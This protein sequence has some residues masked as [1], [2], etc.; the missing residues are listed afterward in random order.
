[1]KTQQRWEGEQ[2][3][4]SHHNPTLFLIRHY[5]KLIVAPRLDPTFH[6]KI[7]PIPKPDLPHTQVAH[8]P[9]NNPTTII[10]AMSITTPHSAPVSL[11]SSHV[12]PPL[13]VYPNIPPRT[14][15]ATN[16][17]V[18]ESFPNPNSSAYLP[19]PKPTSHDRSPQLAHAALRPSHPAKPKKMLES[20][21]LCKQN[22]TV[23]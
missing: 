4:H 22:R 17:W 6:D 14:T 15:S 21:K 12:P 18:S 7:N 9:A 23:R 13:A 19:A 8:P 16:P 11:P 20:G 3:D 2:M 10:P 5:H 1:M